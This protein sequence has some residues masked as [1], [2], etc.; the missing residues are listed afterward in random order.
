MTFATPV[1]QQQCQKS[2]SEKVWKSLIIVPPKLF[3]FFFQKEY[4][5]NYNRYRNK[6]WIH[7]YKRKPQHNWFSNP[8]FS[9]E[10]EKR[11]TCV[12]CIAFDI[13]LVSERFFIRTSIL[14]FSCSYVP[15]I[16]YISSS[17]HLSL[18]LAG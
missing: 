13:F 7:T 12:L 11:G 17:F 8:S 5:N 3:E 14:G 4:R 15:L 10:E 6:I 16:L 2:K 1:K 18:Y 9:V